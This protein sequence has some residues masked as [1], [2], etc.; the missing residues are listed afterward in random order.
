MVY[1]DQVMTFFQEQRDQFLSDLSRLISIESV[2]SEALPGKP[3]GIG[4]DQALQFALSLAESF[5]LHGQ[6][7]DGR[8]IVVELNKEEP[9]LDI[10]AHLDVVPGGGGWTKTEPFCA[11]IDGSRIYGRGA[12]DDKGPALAALYAF[13][14][15]NQ[16]G[17]PLQ[18]GARLILGIDEESGSSDLSY[19]YQHYEES[20]FTFTPDAEF[21]LV[22]SEKGGFFGQF[23]I[24]LPTCQRPVIYSIHAGERGNVIPGRAEAVV[25][26]V[27]AEDLAVLARRTA[28]ESNTEIQ[29]FPV[30]KGMQILVKGKQNHAAYPEC[31]VNALTVLLQLLSVLPLKDSADRQALLFLQ[32][33][34]PHGDWYG[35]A[36][37]LSMA[38]IETGPLTI[39][40]TILVY[41]P[42]LLKGQF[43]SRIPLC[44]QKETLEGIHEVF[45]RAG[46]SLNTKYI[47]PHYV[48]ENHPFLV[49]L[50]KCYEQFSGKEGKAISSCG[51][52]YV[53]HL[54]KGVA[55]GCATKEIDNHM[56]GPDEFAVIDDL[57]M[58]GA[59]FTQA[60]AELC[61]D[62][63]P[64]HP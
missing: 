61:G 4:P 17:I 50:L 3:Y 39:S 11:K 40:P 1:K 34:F 15:I 64:F 10:W 30:E 24:A 55:F 9:Q 23:Q 7:L 21:P 48:P 60:I 44:A 6:I 37:G 8:L 56:H 33:I 58:S 26:D 22:N 47:P 59:I 43:D 20:P 41:Q 12:A 18:K 28:Q 62:S 46:F 16:L 36:L 45:Q 25:C 32:R 63:T 51:M 57:L 42:G 19:Y 53:H 49:T 5:G 14:A 2:R 29:L 13:R 54:K 27:P 31:G 38:D 35:D 52:T